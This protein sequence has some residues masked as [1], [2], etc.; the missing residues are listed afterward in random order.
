MRNALEGFESSVTVGGRRISNLRY[1]DDT[2]L[3]AGSMTD[4]QELVERVRSYS[5][6]AGLFLNA[7]KTKV[8]KIL[9]N[10]ADEV[11]DHIF[12]N[13]EPVE[14]VQKFI[15]LGATFTNDYDDSDE[16]KRRI[17]I[18]K[19][20]TVALTNIWKNR[21]I[22][23]KTKKR[24]L[25]SLVFSIA[26]YGS[27]CWVLKNSDIKKIKSFELWCYRRLLR[28]SWVEKISNE[29]V[30][31]RSGC[32]R[33]LMDIINERKLTFIGHVLRSDHLTKL[34]LTGMVYGP[35]GKG[36]PKTRYSDC[37]RTT[38]GISMADA[39]RM[40]QDRESWRNRVQRATAGRTRP[41]RS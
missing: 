34:L 11:D 25:N 37:L 23:L 38:C 9:R 21:S 26:C 16:I 5:E 13:G 32:Q 12:I 17:G 29:E 35:R 4:L 7:K 36:R 8:M 3:I 27:E 15:Y 41:I 2:V 31:R 33:R 24:L 20:A 6:A 18:A 40:A 22:S 10:P 1:A 28:I 14:N 39:V 30:I 19:N